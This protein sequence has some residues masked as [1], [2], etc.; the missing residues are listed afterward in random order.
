MFT[1]GNKE[2]RN[3][4]LKCFQAVNGGQGQKK[5]KMSDKWSVSWNKI[6]LYLGC[7]HFTVL[8]ISTI[9]NFLQ[10]ELIC[11]KKQKQKTNKNLSR[12]CE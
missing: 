10:D 5:L 4:I 2:E 7:Y 6:V 12:E 1:N 8:T 9:F 11:E 3:A